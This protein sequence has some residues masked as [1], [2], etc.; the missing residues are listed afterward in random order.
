MAMWSGSTAT[1]SPSPSTRPAKRRWSIVS[2]SGCRFIGS[3]PSRSGIKCWLWLGHAMLRDSRDIVRRLEREG[4]ERIS[5]NGSHHKFRHRV[6]KRMVIVP[7]PRRDIALGTVR[8][9][10]RQAGWSKD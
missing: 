5:V 4:F 9:I 1:N 2:W 10:Y 7:H 3:R 6:S 8:S